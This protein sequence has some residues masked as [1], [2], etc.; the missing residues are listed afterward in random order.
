MRY[1]LV[2]AVLLSGTTLCRKQS[3]QHRQGFSDG[4]KTKPRRENGYRVDTD[5]F[6]G[7]YTL[8]PRYGSDRFRIEGDL[9]TPESCT[10]RLRRGKSYC[11]DGDRDL[12]QTRTMKPR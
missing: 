5:N 7:F 6:N 2:S 12:N 9:D 11:V 8:K 1:F 3:I 10:V 4:A